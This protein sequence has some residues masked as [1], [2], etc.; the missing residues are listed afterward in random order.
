MKIP[1]SALAISV[2]ASPF[3]CL[4]RVSIFRLDLEFLE[5]EN[6]KSLFAQS[7]EQHMSMKTPLFTASTPPRHPSRT[8]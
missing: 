8:C 5:G 7:N 3:T 1:V 4:L 2:P 6:S